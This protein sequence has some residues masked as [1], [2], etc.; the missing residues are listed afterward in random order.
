VNEIKR[1]QRPARNGYI[2]FEDDEPPS[3]VTMVKQTEF[4]SSNGSSGEP[5]LATREKGKHLFDAAVKALVDF[6]SAFKSWPFLD[7]LRPQ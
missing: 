2:P 3:G 6:I 7:N 4:I 5:N 1:S